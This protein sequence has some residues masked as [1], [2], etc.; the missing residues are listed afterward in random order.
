MAEQQRLQPGGDDRRGHLGE[1]HR[2]HAPARLHI[3]HEG[4]EG[5]GAERQ[6]RLRPRH[7]PR[8]D[9][10]GRQGGL[11]RALGRGARQERAATSAPPITPAWRSRSSGGQRRL[12]R[13]S[14]ALRVGAAH[15]HELARVRRADLGPQRRVQRPG[16]R[17]TGLRL[18]RSVSNRAPPR[19][20]E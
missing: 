4:R 18:A 10:G 15:Q 2:R 5:V 7:P 13:R 14:T 19:R 11:A 20:T 17:G 12:L 3:V 6:P 16:A 8:E 1:G 9:R